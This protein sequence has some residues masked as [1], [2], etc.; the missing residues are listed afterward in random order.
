MSAFGQALSEL[1]SVLEEI[2]ADDIGRA[3]GMIA[4]A[5]VI[6]GYGCGREGLQ[7]QG[8]VMRLH[9][10]GL[11]ASMQGAM[12]TPPL[13]SG[14]V[15]LCSAGPGELSTVTALMEVARNAGARILF[16]TAEPECEAARIA[17]HVLTVPA[18][19]MARDIG[20]SSVL[21]MGSVYE[22]AL[23]VLFEIMVLELKKRLGETSES[24]R[25]RHTN[26]E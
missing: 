4:E 17:D 22:G 15:F 19:T 12:N 24:M 1:G 20:G 9:H 11:K 21:P 2:R 3:V 13:G 16:L 14:D 26:M 8:L 5:G 25:A 7:V 18:Q 6:V 10:L 23:F